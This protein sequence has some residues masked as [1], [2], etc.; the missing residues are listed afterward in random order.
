[1]L[2]FNLDQLYGRIHI[3]PKEHRT[4]MSITVGDFS[5][6]Q[7]QQQQCVPVKNLLEK[8]MAED[9]YVRHL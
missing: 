5:I 3:S 4:E 1:M 7:M 8:K 9:R 2:T 6:Q